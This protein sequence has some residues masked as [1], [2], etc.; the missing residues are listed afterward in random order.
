VA[1][2]PAAS[3]LSCQ[4]PHDISLL[5]TIA[6]GLGLAFAM[7]LLATRVRL[8]PI[9]GYLVAGIVVGPF[10]PGFVADTGLAS[11]LAELGVIFLM[12]GVGLHFSVR[13]L[14]AVR[15]IAVPGAIG[16]AL[17]A[18]VLG[19]LVARAWGWS[20]GSGLV[21]GLSLSVAST[22]VLLRTLDDHGILDSA[23]GQIAVGWLIVEDLLT[24]LALVLLPALAP[25]LGG[26]AAAV[27]GPADA[28]ALDPAAGQHAAAGSISLPVVI[29]STLLK[30]V[31]FAAMMLVVGKRLIP[32]LLGR[33]VHTG[34]RELFTLA[35]LSVALCI[36]V[37]AAAL[38]DVS[39]ALGAF[40]AGVIV[41]ES[42]FSHEAAR[43]ALPLQDAFAVLFFVSVGMLFDPAILVR[44]PLRL[45]A[46]V[47]I[48][49]I[50]KSIA[51]LLIVLAFRYT[52]HTALTISASLAQIG[53]FSFILVALGFSLG[54]LPAEAQSLV[55]AGAL[56]S[57]TVN[58]FLF[59]LLTPLSR[60]LRERRGLAGA[61]ERPAGDLANL[62]EAQEEQLSGH[63]VVVGSGR[64]GG[65]VANELARHGI[66]YVI[67]EQSREMIESLRERGLPA[68]YG[69]ASRPEVMK[70][71]HLE[72]A[73][74]VI[75]AAPDAYQ[76][77]AIL[78]LAH[79]LNP[80]LEVIVRTHSQNEREFLEEMGAARALVAES[81]L[82]VSL[83]REALQRFNVS[84]DMNEIALRALQLQRPVV[85][86][87]ADDG[88]DE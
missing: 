37:G 61:L 54:L 26:D 35:V 3:G 72:R 59:Q 45:L 79:Q 39:F 23:D 81:E 60:W 4:M 65:P 68:I 64:V 27:L 50:G 6:A 15:H 67:V 30:L 5:T 57:I 47:G 63:V 58:P 22:V 44:E 14:L 2:T 70:D 34:S 82:A 18:T 41:S 1:S 55:V 74:L 25:A 52:V 9:L 86:A 19:M 46:V 33:V 76:A 17:F 8:P 32:A 56:V 48:I 80:G 87:R 38:F 62:P 21:F 43:N 10:T 13:D 66:P 12:F 84:F 75:V 20:Y 53:E 71:A 7:G 88:Q 36:A 78:A 29:G 85:P 28:A 69:D 31:L 24:V 83:S 42:D 51:A 73:R 40:F 16:Q 49:L 77:R 11:Q